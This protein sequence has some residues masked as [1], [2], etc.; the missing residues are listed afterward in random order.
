MC[1]QSELFVSSEAVANGPVWM[2]ALAQSVAAMCKS[3]DA[4]NAQVCHGLVAVDV[5]VSD[6]M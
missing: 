1:L 2:K 4:L 5:A 3:V 6:V